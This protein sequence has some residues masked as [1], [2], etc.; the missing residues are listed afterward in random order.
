MF[1]VNLALGPVGF[2]G[3]GCPGAAG[4]VLSR[5]LHEVGGVADGPRRYAENTERHASWG[6]DS[7]SRDHVGEI[8]VAR[9]M[10]RFSTPRNFVQEASSVVAL[11]RFPAQVA[12]RLPV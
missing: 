4:G 11:G 12:A 2:D 3:F 10:A 1:F 7:R 9:P 5:V 8:G 6:S